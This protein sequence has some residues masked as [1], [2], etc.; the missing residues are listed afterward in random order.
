MK[1]TSDN[2]QDSSSESTDNLNINICR[3]SHLVISERQ[4]KINL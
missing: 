4:K 3:D 1:N 2:K